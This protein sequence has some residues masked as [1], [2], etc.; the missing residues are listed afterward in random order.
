[1]G[2]LKLFNS[3]TLTEKI[4]I[5]VLGLVILIS[6]FQIGNKFY[7]KNSEPVAANG[8]T[9]VEGVVGEFNFLNPV[10]AQT[11]LDRD[12]TSLIFCGLTRFDPVSNSIVDGIADHTLSADQRT[13]TFKIKE[14]VKW[15]DGTLVTADDVIFTFRDVLQNENFPNPGLASDFFDVLITKIDEQT[16]TMTLQ[17][18]YA[19]FVYNTSIGLLPKHL[20]GDIP[21][22]ELLASEFNLNPVGCGPYLVDS[23]GSNAIRLSAFPDFYRGRP[24]VDSIIFR[25]FPSEDELLKNLEG[26]IGTKDLNEKNIK[27]FENDARLELH[28]FT[29]PQYVGL[30]FNTDRE[31]L[32]DKKLRL[33]LQLATNKEKI[34]EARGG[35]VKIIDTPLLEIASADWKYEFDAAR[36]DGAL[37]D[38]GWQYRETEVAT[39]ESQENESP[40]EEISVSIG[41]PD[42]NPQVQTANFITLP[43]ANDFFATSETEF[44][45]EGTAPDDSTKIVVNGYQLSRFTA[46]SDSWSYKASLA[47][48]TLKDGENE[49]VIENQNGEIDRVKIFYASDQAE[50]DEWSATQ[51]PVVEAEIIPEAPVE[52]ADEEKSKP[53]SLRLRYKDDE[54]LALRLLIPEAREEFLPIAE[55][56]ASQWRE[57]GVKL[58]IERLPE[59]EFITRMTKRDYD[60]VLFGQNLGYNLDAYSFWHSS[61]AREGGNNLSNLKLSAVNSRLE[62]IRSSFDST[63][64]RKRLADLREVLS[65]EVPAVMLYTPT[66]SYAVDKKIQGFNLGRIALKRD[67]LT[68][69]PSWYI[70]ESRKATVDLGVW[71]FLKWFFTEAL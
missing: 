45:L 10:L 17:K 12:L 65:E 28:D 49:Y 16:V 68:N 24:F 18:K 20:L 48:Q 43:S 41:N 58:T 71:N 1:V 38:A 13:Y 34:A 19:F 62:Q 30:F 29:L 22:A 50:R 63:E 40:E 5:G 6:S 46:G 57:R 70:R 61:E 64:R 23:V 60:I 25:I 55:E 66:Y 36:A 9:F 51:E 33:G 4:L 3:C 37:F 54:P 2:I 39:D 8:G 52:E 42:S 53:T 59:V 31:I 67:R 69:L 47:L 32:K 7:I 35:R 21:P 56:I 15:H 27:A 26:I 11:N 14:G 44:F